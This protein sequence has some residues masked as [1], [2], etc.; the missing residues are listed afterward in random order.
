MEDFH[1]AG[2]VP[3]VMEEILPLLDDTL[4][5]ITG[6]TLGQNLKHGQIATTA[7]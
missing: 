2:G 5:T 1:Q 3:A 4:M 7:T 6:E